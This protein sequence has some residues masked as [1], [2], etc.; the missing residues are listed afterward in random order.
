M[1]QTNTLITFSVILTTACAVESTS[2]LVDGIN[3]HQK[4]AASNATDAGDAATVAST[5]ARGFVIVHSDYSTSSVSAVDTDGKVL[6]KTLVTSGS[7]PPGLSL[8]LGADTVLPS[9]VQRGE[10]IVLIDRSN[11]ALHWLNLERAEVT[12]QVSVGPGGF[13]AN[14]YDYVRVD[15]K[16]A[17]VTRFASNE[18]PGNEEF[19]EG[20]D[21]LALNPK[22]GSL[23]GRVDFNYLTESVGGLQPRPSN[24][25]LRD[26]Q[27]YVVLGFLDGAFS[28]LENSRLAKVNP[29]QLTVESTLDLGLRNCSGSSLSPNSEWLAVACTGDWQDDPVTQSSGIVLVDVTADAPR[30]EATY[31]AD[32]L[33]GMQISGVS[34][35]SD[36]YLLFTSYGA[37]GENTTPERA[38][39]FDLTSGEVA[40]EPLAEA[41]PFNLG[42]AFCLPADGVCAIG[43][44]EA[45]EVELFTV[46]GNDLDSAVQSLHKVEVDDGIGLPPRYIG[47]F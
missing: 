37:T 2:P 18:D 42:M 45:G 7:R 3:P 16:L 15:S 19:D 11:H 47:A 29:E 36:R 38:W 33:V 5:G 44:A 32:D 14:P 9:Q 17:L 13:A 1:R 41:A 43:N 8:A 31:E 40:E 25:A 12:R 35:A 21:L 39:L 24:L 22:D 10:E 28:A 20:G 30:L 26:D 23:I 27:V 6:A 4:D 46:L 34:L